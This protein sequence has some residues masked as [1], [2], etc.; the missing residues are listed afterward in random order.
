MEQVLEQIV[1]DVISLYVYRGHEDYFGEKVSQIE[2]MT[3][4]AALAEK[5]GY[6]EEVILAA[7]FHDIGH[8]C[9]H[10]MPV[11]KMEDYGVVNHESLGAEFLLQKGFSPTIIKL[12]NKHVE[13][14]RYLAFKNPEYY[15]VLSDASK[16]TLVFQGGIMSE[17]EAIKFEEDPL[18]PLYIKMR[19]WDDQ[20]KVE[21]IPIPSLDK[22][23][24]MA[25]HHLKRKFI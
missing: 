20:A 17:Q 9:E 4:A 22:F 1:N 23:R 3:Q 25:I 21:N 15:E 18:H 14:K 24:K 7:F 5:E 11:S 12:V 10:I 19:L 13:A 8:L 16:R 6:D 2:H